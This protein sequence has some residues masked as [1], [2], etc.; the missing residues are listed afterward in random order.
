[1]RP[2]QWIKNGFVFIPFLF[3]GKLLDI[4]ILSKGVLVFIAFCLA[5]SCIYIFND[6]SDI[7]F[8][9]K[10][11]ERKTRPLASRK[12]N[13]AVAVIIMLFLSAGAVLL[14]FSHSI[15]VG[16]VIVS[17]ILLNIFY[18]LYLKDIVILDIFCV[19]LGF[20]LRVL[21]GSY[22]CTVPPSHWIILMTMALSLLLAVGKRRG[23]LLTI[24]E[25]LRKHRKVLRA[26]SIH[27]IDQMIVILSGMILI[28][29]SLYSVS[30]YAI[31]RF[32][33]DA[34]VYTVPLVAYGIF[35]YIYLINDKKNTSDP[36]KILFSDRHMFF[37]V[38]AWLAACAFIIYK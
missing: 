31:N 38:I 15:E 1:M 22:A 32:R 27:A 29:F 26:Y 11:P 35:R 36:T 14:S 28:T 5:S 20:L 25:D 33:T 16:L 2:K 8:D 37:C 17:Y 12:L 24:D 13:T 21:A 7:E 18:S 3:S 6:L 9:R 23:D 10:H 34:L 4:H 19:A 30:D